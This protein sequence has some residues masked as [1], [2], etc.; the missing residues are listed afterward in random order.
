M[1]T[2]WVNKTVQ[3]YAIFYNFPILRL[4]KTV[5]HKKSTFE[6]SFFVSNTYICA[7]NLHTFYAIRTQ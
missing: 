2:L 1:A 4:Q 5:F 6:L 7:P 3:K